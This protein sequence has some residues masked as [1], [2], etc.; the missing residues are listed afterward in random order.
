MSSVSLQTWSIFAKLF[1]ERPFEV[2]GMSVLV[3]LHVN[4]AGSFELS[5]DELQGASD[6]VA[7]ISRLILE[8]PG[9]KP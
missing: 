8:V 5:T 6:R 3:G 1:Q 4:V 9:P 7:H 2:E